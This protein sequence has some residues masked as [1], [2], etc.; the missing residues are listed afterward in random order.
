MWRNLIDT[1]VVPLPDS[2]TTSQP[3]YASDHSIVM[4]FCQSSLA[5]PTLVAA[6]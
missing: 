5:L 4:T 2:C 1:D 6:R 3:S